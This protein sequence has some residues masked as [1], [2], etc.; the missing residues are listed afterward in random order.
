MAHKPVLMSS[1]KECGYQVNYTSTILAFLKQVM[2]V[3]NNLLL[4]W[5]K[6][7][8]RE[9][10]VQLVQNGKICQIKSA[11]T[12]IFFSLHQIKS[13]PNLIIFSLHQIKSMAK[14]LFF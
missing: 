1:G 12:L 2:A 6:F 4:Y 3:S 8:C 13:V 11:L 10:L 7:W 5:D 9:N 14:K